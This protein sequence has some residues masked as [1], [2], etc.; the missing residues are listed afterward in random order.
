MELCRGQGPPCCQEMPDA[1]FGVH[2]KAEVKYLQTPGPPISSD[3]TAGNYRYLWKIV[4][5]RVIL[6]S[7]L[8]STPRSTF[9]CISQSKPSLSLSIRFL[10]LLVFSA[11]T[12]WH[13]S[14]RSAP[15]VHCNTIRQL[16][17]KLFVVLANTSAQFTSLRGSICGSQY[18]SALCIRDTA[19]I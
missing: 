1:N 15:A 10:R 13:R 12:S 11:A 18:Y 5:A 9:C 16:I 8:L 17:A 19:R 3:I 7:Y 6:L 14:A 2:V 4:E